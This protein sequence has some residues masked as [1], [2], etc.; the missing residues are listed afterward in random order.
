MTR[1]LTLTLALL[2]V[3]LLAPPALGAGGP[4]AGTDAGPEGVTAP[5]DPSRYA[6]FRT[7]GGTLVEQIQRDGGQITGWRFLRRALTLP[8]VAFDGSATGLS[9][10]GRTLVLASPRSGRPRRH[11][12]FAVLDAQRLRPRFETTLRGDFTLDAI[13]PDGNRLFLIQY[14]SRRDF[15]RYTVR[16]YDVGARRLLARPI[17]DPAEADEPMRGNPLARAMS[18]DGRWA[19]TLY[20]GNGEHPFIHALDTV[21]ARAKCVDLDQLAGRQDLFGL[22]LGIDRSG[23][24]VVREPEHHAALLVV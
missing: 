13:S 23:A 3:A 11:S 12:G 4:V 18:A 14:T 22:G 8:V 5:G 16:A 20:D 21:A 1:R 9:A 7:G 2:T 15:S 10:D 19:Y 17:V 24:L 6:T